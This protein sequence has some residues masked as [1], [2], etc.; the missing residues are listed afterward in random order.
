MTDRQVIICDTETTS[1]RPD[2]AIL[3]VAAVNLGTGE[4]IRFVPFVTAEQLAHADPRAMQVNRYYERGIWADTLSPDDTAVQYHKLHGWL[5]DNVLA[6][7]NPAFDGE[8]LAQVG[9]T[10]PHE[11]VSFGGKPL[12]RI[13]HTPWHH[14]LGDISTYAAGVLGLPLSDLPGLHKVCELLDV[15]NEEEH[16]ALGDARATAECFRQ[17]AHLSDHGGLVNA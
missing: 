5:V 11:Y 1:L 16:S 7:S 9:Y 13:F 10:D 8:K 3:E 6:G 17:L 4:E 12:R 14:R 2:A 15:M